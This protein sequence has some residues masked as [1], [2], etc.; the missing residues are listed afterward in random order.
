MFQFLSKCLIGFS[1]LC[2]LACSGEQKERALAAANFFLRGNDKWK[3]KEYFEA[4]KWY[5]EAIIQQPDFADA[6]YNRGMVYQQLER[7]EEALANFEK[8]QQLDEN[9]PA[10]VYKKIEVR[11]SLNQLDQAEL[12]AQALVKKYPDSARF[13]RIYGDVLLTKSNLNQALAQYQW[14]LKL[15]PNLV[16]ARINE[17]VVFQEMDALDEAEKSFRLALASGQFKDLIYNNLGYIEIQR[18]Q[19]AL[20]LDWVKKAL[21]LDPK[22]ALYQKNLARIQAE[23]GLK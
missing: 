15:Q 9:F 16:E 13:H 4:I 5:N 8:A 12:E 2:F 21:A 1:C 3:E 6:Y 20:A 19:Y 18:K 23:S 11:Q 17:G 10:A 7:L 22:N 14:A